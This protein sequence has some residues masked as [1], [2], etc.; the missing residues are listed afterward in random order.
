MLG[1]ILRMMQSVVTHEATI[2]R[3]EQISVGTSQPGQHVEHYAINGRKDRS[4]EMEL[5]EELD[6]VRVVIVRH[7][8]LFYSSPSPSF[9]FI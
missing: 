7:S 4:G 3:K 1:T 5:Q 2:C 8:W 6:P 9:L